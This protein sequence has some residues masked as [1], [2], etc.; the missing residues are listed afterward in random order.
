MLYVV[1]ALLGRASRLDGTQLA[2]VWPAAAV[3]YLWLVWSAQRGR[4]AVDAVLVGVLAGLVNW[5]TGASALMAVGFAVANPVQALVAVL[6]VR[7][8]AGDWRLRT[9][10][11]LAALVA[12]SFGGAV[13]GAAVGC[14]AM[15]ALLGVDLPST[16]GAWVLRNGSNTFVFGAVLL[17]LTDLGW[18]S[19]G[20]GR[21]AGEWSG[22]VAALT[23]LYLGVFGAA[24]PRPVAW[25]VIPLTVWVALRFSTTTAAAHVLLAGVFVVALTAAGRG[26]F[27]AEPPTGRVV[28]AQGFVCV[29]ALIALTLAV[30]QDE[31]RALLAAVSEQGRQLAMQ[32]GLLETVLDT[33]EV[34][35]VACDAG[36]HLSLFNRAAREF[37][38]LG[39]DP[40]LTADD[41]PQ[42]YA[43]LAE[44]GVTPL[45]PEQVPLVQALRGQWVHDQVLHIAPTGLPGRTV[46]VDGRQLQGA[47]GAQLGA[48]VAMT[49]IT[50]LQASERQFREA[51]LAGPTASAR[52]GP[53]GV[54]EQ[55]NPALRRLLA[56][57]S[58]RLLGRA[59]PELAHPDD[60]GRLRALLA[61]PA[62]GP[63]E[64]RLGQ[65]AGGVVW[66]EVSATALTTSAPSGASS[67]GASGGAGA[68]LVQLVDVH[69]RMLRERQLELDAQRDPLTGLA[70]RSVAT[71]R[72][73]Q[74]ALRGPGELALLV[75][76]DL[77][78]FKQVNDAYGHGAGDA[79][80]RVVGERL[81]TVVRTG[82]EVVRLG[83]DEFLLICAVQPAEVESACRAVVGRV[84]AL[85]PQPVRYGG[86]ELAV[87]VSVGTTIAAGG[88]DPATAL[89]LADQAMYE[90]KRARQATG[91]GQTVGPL[92]E[93]RRLLAL[94]E[95]GGLDGPFDPVLDELVRAAAQAAAVPTALVSLVGA[96][97]QVF[98]ARCGLD[99]TGTSRQV[100]FCAHVVDGD[101]ELH[102]PDTRLDARF[103]DN[104]LVTG[105]L[106]IRSYAGFPLRTPHGYVLGSL[107]AIDYQ[108]R[109]LDDRQRQALREIARQVAQHL[110]TSS[111]VLPAVPAS[112]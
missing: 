44:D 97:R 68:L 28:L 25:F 100:S 40:D 1:S 10:R 82:D 42:R 55:V 72:L 43:L 53:D 39:P 77:D 13:A 108:P 73:E 36:G 112:F 3:G 71:A 7:R 81:R 84:E 88:C 78:G 12:G 83:G 51:F 33:I 110:V 86:D 74:L 50:R 16:F 6:L 94:E 23:G 31:R 60:A 26:P 4:L 22:T 20:S 99:E 106:G 70:N 45:Q 102:V 69:T 67:A 37:H 54:V 91:A 66:C 8:L 85:V 96:D 27:A 11:Q 61:D 62:S 52:T 98:R 38:G 107:C 17:R 95:L 14:V 15:A 34:A 65:A 49:D 93:A 57:P 2:L 46:R 48:V 111:S 59:L 30:H 109:R 24:Q 92:V 58:S 75:Y 32:A 29:L 63:V 21:R 80:L 79:V 18:R 76:L 9:G 19:L 104:P 87:G 56:L 35:V 89:T 105:P 5:W 41:W 47:D 101:A 103:S 90:R 64:V